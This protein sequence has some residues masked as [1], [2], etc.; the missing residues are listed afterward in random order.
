[1]AMMS[2]ECRP[3]A[4]GGTEPPAGGLDRVLRF[5]SV[6]TMVMTLPQVYSVWSD[7]RPGGVSLLSWGAYLLS[8]CLWFVYGLRKRD[9]TI[10]LACIGWILLDIAIIAGVIVRG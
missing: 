2:P 1:M 5:M 6:A 7:A 9:K 8:A 10:Y 3:A 4:S